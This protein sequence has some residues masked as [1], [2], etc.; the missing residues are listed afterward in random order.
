MQ[1]SEDKVVSIHYTLTN[2]SGEVI[3]KTSDGD[4]SP[5]VYFHG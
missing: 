3:D 4:G 2:A 5:L 1:A